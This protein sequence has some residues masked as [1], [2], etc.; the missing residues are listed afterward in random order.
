LTVHIGAAG[1]RLLALPLLVLVLLLVFPASASAHV[2]STTG[3]SEIRAE[4]TAVRY[5]LSLE[6]ELLVASTGLGQA[7]LDTAGDGPR[8]AALQH[9]LG[10]I[11]SYLLPR[12]RIFLDGVECPAEVE[13]AAAGTRQEVSQA[14]VTLRYT[15]SGDPGG[16]YELRY[17]VFGERDGLV[18]EHVNIVDYDLGGDRGR[19]V[20]DGAHREVALGAARPFASS[21]RF[22]ELGVEHILGGLDHVLFVAAL[23]IGA[24]TLRQVL[25]VA[26]TFTVAHS[27]T[28]GLA[29]IG[30]VDVPG[31]VVEPLIA[32]SIAYVAA[33]N[34]VGTGMSNRVPVVFVFGLL[35]GLGFAGSLSF[36]D[37][38]SWRLLTSLLT[39]NVGI[40]IGQALI[41]LVLF[42]LLV[43][44][45]RH[46]WSAAVH[47]AATSA[48][49]CVGLVWFCERLLLA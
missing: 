14:V 3:Y 37:D 23:L 11:G 10:S 40:E 8:T 38:V 22:V 24:R 2:R 31:S 6:Y 26:T 42:P 35:H 25:T 44:L 28:L 9:G 41:V 13:S 39:F 36:T 21:L 17:D 29:A 47:V 43:L 1:R 18:D 5:Q 49:G 20:V 33:D 30:G 7:A 34:I 27:I 15:C 48:V 4:G 16:G 12:V 45:R 19:A 32:L 46:R